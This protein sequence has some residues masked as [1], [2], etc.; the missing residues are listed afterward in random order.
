MDD[1]SKCTSSDCSAVGAVV[2]AQIVPNDLLIVAV[3]LEARVPSELPASIT[4]AFAVH[5]LA[6]PVLIEYVSLPTLPSTAKIGLRHHVVDCSVAPIQD[7]LAATAFVNPT[8]RTVP[9]EQSI[10][11]TS[12]LRHLSSF[13]SSL[14]RMTAL[15]SLSLSPA[16]RNTP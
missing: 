15:T 3:A 5:G 1:T 12:S 16:P 13:P 10:Q 2:D 9:L 4:I 6:I 11:L 14:A 7:F 8:K